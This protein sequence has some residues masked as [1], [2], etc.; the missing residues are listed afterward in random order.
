MSS[1]A[2]NVARV[3][4]SI[5]LALLLT[6]VAALPARPVS[7]M[8]A[9]SLV[10]AMEGPVAQA[11]A[12]RGLTFQGEGRGSQEIANLMLAGLRKPD[13]V[14]LVDPSVLLRLRRA[15]LIARSWPLGSASLGIG[16]A[17]R[18]RFA[19]ALAAARGAA[20]LRRVL[21][22]PGIRI[23]RTDPQLD[24]KGRYTVEAVT[25]LYGTAGARSIL[26]ASDNPAQIFPEQDLLVR[27]ETGEADVGFL[28][29]TEARARHLD[30]IPL[31]GAASMSQKIR[32]VVAIVRGAPHPAAA[33][34]FADFLLRGEG[35][36][37]L[38][39][40]GLSYP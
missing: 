1:P 21:S 36:A 29:S 28:Y 34:A 20:A 9:G 40:L 32:Y 16:W 37:I 22:A 18:S 17:P 27:L 15:G 38:H 12:R 8:Y 10:T 13:A 24:P 23:A 19:A 33:S 4:R 3:R 30:F 25:L 14:V 26:G 31:P 39:A 6:L 7:V 5:A 11:L 2:E 35:H